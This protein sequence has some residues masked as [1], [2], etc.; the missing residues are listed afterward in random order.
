[1]LEN[2]PGHMPTTA[3]VALLIVTHEATYK[4]V[5]PED[6]IILVSYKTR[7]LLWQEAHSNP[8]CLHMKQV[9]QGD[10][11]RNEIFDY[12]FLAIAEMPAD[13]I[14]IMQRPNYGE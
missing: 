6:C 7:G 3:I 2:T 4:N 9:R 8:F 1:M 5:A 13:R 11:F 14:L 10:K 12:E